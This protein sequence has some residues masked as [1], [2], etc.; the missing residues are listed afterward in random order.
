MN[1]CVWCNKLCRVKE[2]PKP[3]YDTVCSKECHKKEMQFRLRF[4][5]EQIGLDNYKDHGV[6]P[7]HRGKK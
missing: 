7:N 2:L 6:N 4:S 3:G 1:A 5:D